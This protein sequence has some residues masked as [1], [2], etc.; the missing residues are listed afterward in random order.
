MIGSESTIDIQTMTQLGSRCSASLRGCQSCMIRC[1]P[2]YLVSGSP[3]HRIEESN[4]ELPVATAIQTLQVGRLM[5]RRT[6]YRRVLLE[7]KDH[8]HGGKRGIQVRDPNLSMTPEV[9][10]VGRHQR[11]RA[12]IWKR[13]ADIMSTMIRKSINAIPITEGLENHLGGHYHSKHILQR[14]G[15]LANSD[16]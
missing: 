8:Q 14:V 2:L 6:L 10:V 3:R 9:D 7:H 1:A 4:I 15:S 5:N 12:M 13:R 11:F 16:I